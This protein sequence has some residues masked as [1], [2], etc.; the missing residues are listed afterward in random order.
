MQEKKTKCVYKTN[1]YFE[2]HN[3]KKSMPDYTYPTRY[4]QV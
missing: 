1:A 3:L 2:S 4:P